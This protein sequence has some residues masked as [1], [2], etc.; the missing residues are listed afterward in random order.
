MGNCLTLFVIV[1]SVGI[2]AVAIGCKKCGGPF[3]LVVHVVDALI[4]GR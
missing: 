2:V 4:G 3:A 1:L